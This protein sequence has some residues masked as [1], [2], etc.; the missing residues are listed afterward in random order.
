M[1]VIDASAIVHAWDNYP[2]GIFPPLWGWLEEGFK[3]GDLCIPQPAMTEVEH[4]A[5][6][7]AAWLRQVGL[8]VLP[9]TN[10]VLRYAQLI[11]DGLGISNDQYHPD[12]VDENDILI[13]A[14][15]R[16]FGAQL[17][18]NES[19]QPTL[20]SNKKK[21]KIPAVCVHILPP[22]CISFLDLVKG[23]GRTFG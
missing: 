10:D 5:P 19:R 2:I 1:L 12:G 17:V 4:V 13:I 15:G 8:K 9:I 14:V 22:P 16:V 6:D 7:C 20:P 18:S 23:S 11:K 21:Y 3:N